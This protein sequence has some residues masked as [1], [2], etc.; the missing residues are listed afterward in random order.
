MSS[1]PTSGQVFFHSDTRSTDSI[2]TFYDKTISG[3]TNSSNNL[4]DYKKGGTIVPDPATYATSN[5]TEESAAPSSALYSDS[6]ALFDNGGVVPS[7]D[8]EAN[9]NIP[10]GTISPSNPIKLT[11]FRSGYKLVNPSV[12]SV[13]LSSQ[14]NQVGWAGTTATA[15]QGFYLQNYASGHGYSN[16]GQ[17]LTVTNSAYSGGTFVGYTIVTFQV[18]HTGLY[19]M[20]GHCSGNEINSAQ[21]QVTGSG[22]VMKDS[23]GSTVTGLQNVALNRFRLFE[24]TLP[25]NTTLTLDVRTT[26][27]SQGSYMFGQIRANCN[28]QR[29]P[30]SATSATNNNMLT[31]G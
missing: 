3:S 20:A 16:Y 27:G 26:S 15:N 6:L 29:H 12:S 19:T 23:S 28:Y 9:T 5:F 13:S 24:V 31:Q 25:A 1:L 7:L 30:N 22:V 10:S 4:T 18:S 11:D 14:A 8:T 2:K 21:I 17:L